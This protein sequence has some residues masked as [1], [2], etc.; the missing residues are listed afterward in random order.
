MED[1]HMR[2]LIGLVQAQAECPSYAKVT[3]DCFFLPIGSVVP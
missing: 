3:L 1:E 2:A